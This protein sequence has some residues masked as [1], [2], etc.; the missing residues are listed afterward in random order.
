MSL[1]NN[2]IRFEAIPS[3]DQDQTI[4]IETEAAWKVTI[5]QSEDQWLTVSPMEGVGNATITLHAERNTG[6]ARSA[7]VT[8]SAV[9]AELLSVSVRQNAQLEGDKYNL[10]SFD[11]MY[12]SGLNDAPN[13]ITLVDHEGCEDGKGL[14]S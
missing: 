13:P 1:S 2:V 11:G 4:Q 12:L 10:D 5:E 9:Q 6:P 8:V 7:I 14:N 3:S